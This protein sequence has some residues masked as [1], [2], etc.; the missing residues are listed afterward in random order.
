MQMESRLKI[1]LLATVFLLSGCVVRTY[2]STRDRVDQDLAG[3]RGYL[4][5][6]IPAG[7]ELKERPTTRSTQVVEIELHPL[8]KFEKK[9]KPKVSDPVIEP[10]VTQEQNKGIIYENIPAMDDAKAAMNFEKYTVQKGDTLQKISDKFYGTT[11]K[12]PKIFDA[13]KDIVKGP[14]K[15]YPGQVINIPQEVNALQEPAEN[16]K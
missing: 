5:G 10:P 9:N 6:Q 1:L 7:S 2:Q 8:I 16:L 14:N 3:N 4:K 12:W 15:L 11:K 13:N